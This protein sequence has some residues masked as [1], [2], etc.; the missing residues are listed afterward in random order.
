MTYADGAPTPE[1]LPASYKPA[2]GNHNCGN[3]RHYKRGFCKLYDAKV[4]EDYYC[5]SWGRIWF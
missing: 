1:S 2:L 3:C 5:L 4:R